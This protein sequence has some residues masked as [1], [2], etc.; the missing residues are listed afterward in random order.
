M[1]T[2]QAMPTATGR[3]WTVVH[4][5]DDPDLLR[6][7]QEFLEGEVF[8]FGTLRVVPSQTFDRALELLR[9]RRVDLLILDVFRGTPEDGNR[10]GLDVLEEWQAVGFAPVVLYTALPESI[11]AAANP[12]V[13]IVTKEHA[14][15]ARLADEI[16]DLFD[17]KIPQA[18]RAIVEH[19]DK[20]L[21][22]YM[23]GFVVAEWGELGPL[24]NQPDFLRL[25][26][27]RLAMGF[28]Q[29]VEPLISEVYPPTIATAPAEEKIHPVEYYVKPPIGTNPLLGDLRRLSR[30]GQDRLYVILWPTCDLVDRGGQ[31]KVERALCARARPLEEFEEFVTWRQAPTP[32]NTVVEKLTALVTNN[33]RSG[34]SDRY[35]FLPPA[36]DIPAMVA[37]FGDL[38]H[39]PVPEL[40]AASR[41]AT[42]ASPFAEAIAVRFVRYLGRVG[43]SDLDLDLVLAAMRR[44]PAAGLGGAGPE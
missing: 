38:E 37:D 15:L 43:T 9:D 41:L 33:R 12:F 7:V 35:H 23:W 19:L 22:T 30:N 42:I 25:L 13:R 24:V 1:T 16:R 2:A 32:S 10:A 17:L 26:L 3:V 6:Q 34:Q 27:H 44:A 11:Q 8:S 28:T 20:T 29:G 4:V 18:H 5:E 36:W 31:C 21:R 40:R 39:V 14:Q